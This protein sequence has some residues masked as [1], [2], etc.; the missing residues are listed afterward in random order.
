MISRV[1]FVQ[2]EYIQIE[3]FRVLFKLNVFSFNGM[4]LS[5]GDDELSEDG[6]NVESESS[7]E[8]HYAGNEYLGGD[9]AAVD[10]GTAPESPL[11][12]LTTTL[13]S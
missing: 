13:L 3:C 8:E 9:E 5:A 12:V 4:A 7:D 2:S 11:S 1:I 10:E 6:L